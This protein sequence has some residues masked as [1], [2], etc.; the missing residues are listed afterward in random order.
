[1]KLCFG[2]Y[3]TVLKLCAHDAVTN[4]ILIS[5]LVGLVDKDAA[6]DEDGLDWLFT[7]LMGCK[8]DFNRTRSAGKDR[9]VGTSRTSIMTL[10][11]KVKTEDIVSEFDEEIV[12]LLI[13]DKKHDAVLYLKNILL[14]DNNATNEHGRTFVK[15]MGVDASYASLMSDIYLPHF[16]AGLFLYAIAIGGNKSE[17]GAE[18]V[19]EI[20]KDDYLERQPL[21]I[22]DFTLVDSPVKQKSAKIVSM[23]TT[24]GEDDL[25]HYF[26]ELKDKFSKVKTLLDN[27]SPRPIYSFYVPN[28][29]SY[30]ATMPGTGS[31]KYYRREVNI[32]DFELPYFLNIT[33]YMI[34]S[35][36]GG[37]GKSMMMRHILM[38]A[39]NDYPKTKILP[40]FL[41]LKDFEQSDVDLVSFIHRKAAI[42][43]P[44]LTR[45]MITSMLTEGTL[46][47]LLD[48][49]DEIHSDFA[50]RFEGALEELVD[51]YPKNHYILSSR[52]YNFRAFTR[53]TVMRL[54][55]FSKKQ[56]IEMIRKLEFHPEEP[57][58]KNKFLKELDRSLFKE[59]EDFASIPLLLTLMMMTHAE[60]ASIPS[61]LHEFYAQAFT[62]LAQK[63]DATK[64]SY[65]RIYR[66]GLTTD[67]FSSSFA[68]F[69]YLTYCSQKFELTGLELSQFYQRMNFFQ[70]LRNY[71]GTLDD[72]IYDLMVNLCLM[73]EENGKYS[74]THRSFQEYFC[75]L[76]FSQLPDAALEQVGRFFERNSLRT[77]ADQTFE[78]LYNMI[79]HRVEK[80]ILLPRLEKLFAKCDE[81]EKDFVLENEG[82]DDE[83]GEGD[84]AYWCF[85]MKQYFS[86]SVGD[87]D[88]KEDYD[89]KP[90]SFLYSFL[91]KKYGALHRRL[92]AGDFEEI[93][94]FCED[95][96][97][98]VPTGPMEDEIVSVDEAPVCNV[99]GDEY[100][101]FDPAGSRYDIDWQDIWY[102]DHSSRHWFMDSV[103]DKSFPLRKE[104][105]AMR[106]VYEEM[107]ERC[108]RNEDRIFSVIL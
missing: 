74:F 63:H 78:M 105:Q 21:F 101:R 56:A 53:F 61:S 104:Y 17:D 7:K 95:S 96:F 73:Y 93:D 64:S 24:F 59:H 20:K 25:T 18:T 28:R 11:H 27:D 72:Y 22:D 90:D 80:T 91:A 82:Y 68:E 38:L 40:V 71:K 88:V 32:D 98:H 69:C 16:L 94:E 77:G 103:N 62:T 12:P 84:P 108:Q 58:I 87:G 99:D 9:E 13:E 51:R 75:A 48:G 92:D 8:A 76:F 10:V 70:D 31:E 85:L 100:D 36:T 52:P 54:E 1:M 41:L 83:C 65:H 102:D 39:I 67:Q 66:T 15:Y 81:F 79:R 55:P 19:A 50:R 35:G 45:D 106:N 5:K 3:A 47:L 97:V 37:L 14:A 42:F 29:I 2:S 30:I 33:K 6:L 107:K 26:S 49:L 46:L 34:L 23:Q 89:A 44:G 43:W 4:R 60:Y 86:I 57:E